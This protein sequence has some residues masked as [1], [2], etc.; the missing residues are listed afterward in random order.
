MRFS[1]RDLRKLLEFQNNAGRERHLSGHN[2]MRSGSGYQPSYGNSRFASGRG[3]R[4]NGGDGRDRAGPS[5]GY[6]PENGGG[7]RT[8][9]YAHRTELLNRTRGPCWGRHLDNSKENL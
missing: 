6:G 3:G 8:L 2:N 4:F 7:R 9:A 1:K 5:Q